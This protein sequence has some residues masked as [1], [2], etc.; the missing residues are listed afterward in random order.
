MSKTFRIGILGCGGIA[1]VHATNLSKHPRAE[2][3]AFCDVDG[4]RT[5]QFNK[6]Y[7]WRWPRNGEFMCLWKS[8]SASI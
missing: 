3:V 5:A 7:N 1:N 8:P 4:K 6:D 2:L